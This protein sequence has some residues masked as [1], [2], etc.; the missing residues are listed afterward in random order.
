MI[1]A[2]SN[3]LLH[4]VGFSNGCVEFTPKKPPPLVPNCLIA[5]WLAAGPRGMTWSTPCTVTAFTYCAKVCG[6][7]CQTRYSASSRHSGNKP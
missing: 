2:I 5:I 6:T 3:R 4:A 1:E 7:P